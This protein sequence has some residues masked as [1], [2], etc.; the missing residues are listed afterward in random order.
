MFASIILDVG[1]VESMRVNGGLLVWLT[2]VG[3]AFSSGRLSAQGTVAE[4]YL[5][6]TA[7]EE[8]AARGLALLVWD[9]ALAKAA[10]AHASLMAEKRETAHGFEGERELVQR[11]S[12]AG[13][14]FT[15]ISENVAEG[16]LATEVQEAWMNSDGHRENLLDPRVTA[17]GI[18]VVER[19]HQ[20]YAV[21]DFAHL[22]KALSLEGQEAAVRRLLLRPGLTVLASTAE[23]R[24]ACTTESA[25]PWSRKPG[26]VM[27][28]TAQTLDR[29]P[30]ELVDRLESKRYREAAVGACLDRGSNGFSLYRLAVLL[31]F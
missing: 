29:L 22:T 26:F 15:L 9:A 4:Q 27:R 2:V 20:L 28:Y 1:F 6:A 5:L 24:S 18:A 31:Y 16:A 13:A 10:G 19:D 12:D 21:E 11:A 14:R 7:N 23:A 25:L 3:F 17:V 8:R 30:H